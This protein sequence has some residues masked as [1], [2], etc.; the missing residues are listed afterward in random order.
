[1][2]TSRVTNQADVLALEAEVLREVVI[3]AN[4]VNQGAR[5]IGVTRPSVLQRDNGLG[6]ATLCS[7]GFALDFFEH[8]FGH[9]R[10]IVGRIAGSYEIAPALHKKDAE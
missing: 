8:G 9:S 10:E 6:Q 2:C 5:R 3:E 7:S 4:G 1:M